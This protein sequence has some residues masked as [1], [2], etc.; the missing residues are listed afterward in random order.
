MANQITACHVLR[1]LE[2]GHGGN[3][4]GSSPAVLCEFVLGKDVFVNLPTGPWEREVSV[5]RCASIRLACEQLLIVSSPVETRARARSRLQ[6]T[7]KT[8][9]SAQLLTDELS[10]E[11]GWGREYTCSFAEKT[12]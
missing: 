7:S 4:S 10:F 6:T 1:L 2:S 8:K 9:N 3:W 12:G 11:Y 5:L